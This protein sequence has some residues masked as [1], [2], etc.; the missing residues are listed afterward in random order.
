LIIKD[1]HDIDPFTSVKHG[2]HVTG[3]ITGDG[4]MGRETG[5]APEAEFITC[6]VIGDKPPR[7]FETDVWEAMGYALEEGAHV[8]NMSGGL[9]HNEGP[10]RAE[11]RENCETIAWGL[12]KIGAPEAW[13]EGYTGEGV[14]V[15]VLDT[16]CDYEHFDLIGQRW[17][18]DVE[19]SG[20]P[21]VD[22]DGNGKKDDFY[23]WNFVEENNDVH[24]IDGHIIKHGTHVT[25]TIAGDGAM[26]TRTGVA[27]DAE[28]MTCVALSNK[29]TGG[30]ESDVWDAMGYAL[31]E[32]ADIINLS[33]GL[34][35]NTVPPPHRG[36]WRETCENLIA[37]GIVLVFAAGND[38]V[39]GADP[40]PHEVATPAD[41]P[42]VI[43]VGATD[44]NDALWYSSSKG[45]TTWEDYPNLIKPGVVAPGVGITSTKAPGPPWGYG[46]LT[47]TSM[48]APHVA[49]LAAL[50]LDAAPELDHKGVFWSILMTAEDLGV[51]GK[52]NEF[53]FGLIKCMDAITYALEGNFADSEMG[54]WCLTQ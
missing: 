6:V 26:G 36:T 19:V 43:A 21:G 51:D 3:I 41:V 25:G 30:F 20:E 45:P 22:D 17:E 34:Y 46:E 5:V 38:D 10:D 44:I 18:N 24:D 52:D 33:G 27:Y 16:G 14:V 48:A 8:I 13:A 4:T 23:G 49:G 47:G 9:Y 35:H 42:C 54:V 1:V 39:H 2:T 31:D 53:G 37:A 29:P 28:F 7:G 50:I 12:T 32:G 40:P 11:W 15:A